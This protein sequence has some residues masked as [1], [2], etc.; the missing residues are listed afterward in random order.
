MLFE[1]RGEQG[2]MIGGQAIIVFRVC[3]SGSC[4]IG[5]NASLISFAD[6]FS[7]SWFFYNCFETLG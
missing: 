6:W 1:L 4:Y 7:I 3:I 5:L 2:N